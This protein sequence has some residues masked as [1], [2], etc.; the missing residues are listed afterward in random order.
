MGLAAVRVLGE[1]ACQE[2]GP[3]R[4]SGRDGRYRVQFESW[5]S[6]LGVGG[7]GS[8][9]RELVLSSAPWKGSLRLQVEGAALILDSGQAKYRFSRVG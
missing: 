7:E 6:E 3:A 4:I 9:V 1:Y 5:A 2:L 8:T